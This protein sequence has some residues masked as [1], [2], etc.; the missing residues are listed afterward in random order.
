M[1]AGRY[2]SLAATDIVDY[3]KRQI[4]TEKSR[5]P[6]YGLG[7]RTKSKREQIKKEE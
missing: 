5:R 7:L 3:R 4:E 1:I 2:Q 6:R